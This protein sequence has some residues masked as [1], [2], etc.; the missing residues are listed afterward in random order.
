MSVLIGKLIALGLDDLAIKE[1]R[2]LKRRLDSPE[3]S[4][5]PKNN[6]AK[7]APS[8]SN[9]QALAEMLEFGKESLGGKRLALVITTQQHILRL[10]VTSQRQKHVGIALPILKPSHHSSPTKLLL[11]AAEDS[12]PDKTARQ[13]QSLSEILLSL[14]PSISPTDDAL[15]L[16]AKVSVA[17][18][19]AIQLQSLAL[20]NRI[21]WWRFA[22]HKGDLAKE[23]FDP[24][25][26]CLSA[27]ARRSQSTPLETYHI[28]VAAFV[29]LRDMLD[30]TNEFKTP[31]V[32]K[33]L[34]GIYRLLG[35]LA[36]EANS[37]DGAI[38]WTEKVQAL[39]DP[40]SDSDARQSSVMARLV[41][42][43][44]RGMPRESDE[45]LVFNLLE[46]L[47]KPFKGELSDI[48]D[49]LTEISS[50]RR[51]A[52]SILAKKGRA[53][54]KL[55]D[56][57]R[58]MCE[59]LVFGCPRFCLR[60]LG[61]PLDNTSATKDIL[62]YEQ[63]R[64]FIEKLGVHAIDSC[65][66]L[67][68]NFLAEGRLTWELTDSNLQ[69]C[70]LL[71]ER[72]HPVAEQTIPT[73]I[74]SRPSYYVRI[75]NLYFSQYLNMRRDS[76]TSKDSQ[77]VRA[78]KRSIDCIHSRPLHE[79]IAAQLSTKLERMA[80][81]CRNTGRFDE[82]FRTLLSLRDE[83]ISKGALT[84]VAF[85]AATEPIHA[86]WAK[87]DETTV[88]GRTVGS[89]VKVQFKCLSP[90]AQ[91][92]LFEGPWSDEERGSLLEHHL[93]VLFNQSNKSSATFAF[94][95][96]VF[97]AVLS[98]YT[99]ESYPVRRLRVISRLLSLEP[100]RYQEISGSL[101][102]ELHLCEI[103]TLRVEGTNDEGLR[104][105]L[106]HFQTLTTTLL[107]LQR[108]RID[109]NILKQCLVKWSSIR[110]HCEDLS[111]L[112][113]EIEDL[114]GFLTHLQLIADYMEMKGFEAVRIAVLRL[115]ADFNQLRDITSD[116][117][118]LVLS[119]SRLGSQW[120]QLGYSGKAGL[121][122][123]RA[124]NHSHLNGVLPET[125]LQLHLSYSDYLLAIGNF[126][127]R[128]ELLT[129]TWAFN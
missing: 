27:F 20:H 85:A 16:E 92:L 124:Q 109:I 100:A 58:E 88:L 94:Q 125:L 83:S 105:Y 123:D 62:R 31:G 47:E 90:T 93:E 106:T 65:L 68:K 34:S 102:N 23:L 103:E 86:A 15:S 121:A 111:A 4:T 51:V 8:I 24:F 1:L 72:S 57:L 18:E 59:T 129:S 120:L 117:N 9:T 77:Q 69:A 32:R 112:E 33:V 89:L 61:N 113:R 11:L 67:M 75:S 98:I 116:P 21:L 71:L 114:P 46:T 95:T 91:A 7:A 74:P 50:V 43:K 41:G 110:E 10:M 84:T 44:L 55:T 56:G 79:R 3:I 64:Q 53:T 39:L 28:G 19:E 101:L 26:R 36:Q 22:G 38:I 73:D 54:N 87:D 2:I 60:Y 14:S 128:F 80:E 30:N 29:D 108:E 78:L 70:L 35:S 97:H 25:Y 5:A 45:G 115:I 119:F 76:E 13:L 107:E 49:L 99:R 40:K 12:K 81:I 118:D 6:A 52:V 104:N 63:R 66:F 122:L 48:D 17:P 42:L 96:K 127:K 37:I 126:D 82:L